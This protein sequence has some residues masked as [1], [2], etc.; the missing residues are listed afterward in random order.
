MP[1]HF[2]CTAQ[3]RQASPCSALTTF[4]PSNAAEASVRACEGL[5]GTEHH[6]VNRSRPR[7]GTDV[8]PGQPLETRRAAFQRDSAVPAPALKHECDTC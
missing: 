4:S 1:P 2:L 6:L 3:E 8:R 7:N 5:G